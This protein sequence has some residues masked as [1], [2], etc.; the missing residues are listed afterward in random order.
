MMGF[1]VSGHP[2]SRYAHQLKRFTSFT[3]GNLITSKDGTEVKIVG[4][5]AKIKQTLTR[6]KQEKMAILKVEDLE[7]AVEVLVF[8]ATY[9]KVAR[10]LLPNTVAL[11]KGRLD[12][13]EETP[14]IIANDLFPLENAYTLIS[15]IS[16]NL[17]GLQENVFLSL[18]EL[19]MSSPGSIP[20]YLHLDTPSRSRINLVVGEGF[21]VSPSEQLVSQIETLIGEKRV[22]L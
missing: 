17:S 9:Q 15:S 1:Y 20:I 19:L 2:L 10:Y 12:L 8:P 21:Y 6:A 11:I 14:K 18:K 5:L 13:R 7:S 3:T 16:I 22:S 4:M